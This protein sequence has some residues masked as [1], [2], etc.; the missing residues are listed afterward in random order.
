MVCHSYGRTQ[1]E[2]VWEETADRHV[3]TYDRKANGCGN[4]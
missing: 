4:I 3:S 2:G 1:V